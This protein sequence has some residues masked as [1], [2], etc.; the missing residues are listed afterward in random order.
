MSPLNVNLSGNCVSFNPI[1]HKPKPPKNKTPGIKKY[2]F[3]N[4]IKQ[5]LY[6]TAIYGLIKTK[7]KNSHFYFITLTYRESKKGEA[8]NKHISEFLEYLDKKESPYIRG[9]YVWVKENTK[10][11]TPHF[12]LLIDLQ[13]KF[14]YC[15]KTRKRKSYQDKSKRFNYQKAMS[16]EYG[17]LS[18]TW[19]RIRGDY[20]RNGLD[21]VE[22]QKPTGIIYYLAKY[23][24]KEDLQDSKTKVWARSHNWIINKLTFEDDKTI[25]KIRNQ[26]KNIS[27]KED[28][29]ENRFYK[30]EYTLHWRICVYE[31]I[32]L[33]IYNTN[34]FEGEVINL[35]SLGLN[36]KYQ[37]RSFDKKKIKARLT[38]V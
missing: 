17:R 14:M 13:F 9:G 7:Q 18:K 2:G 22:I 26:A 31:A 36:E 30:T 35:K 24:T 38:K 23:I 32:K 10:K 21:I 5:S 11:E 19:E 15:E 33:F 37:K 25:K 29:T 12:H 34:V 4:K 16:F 28:Q 8:S 3:T 1:Y 20:S 6:D 27:K